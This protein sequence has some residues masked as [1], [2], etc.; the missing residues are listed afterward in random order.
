M[1]DFEGVL[2]YQV[3]TMKE[4]IAQDVEIRCKAALDE[5]RQRA[6]ALL[7][8]TRRRARQRVRQAVV[9]GRIEDPWT[10]Y[11]KLIEVEIELLRRHIGEARAAAAVEIGKAGKYKHYINM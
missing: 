3:R 9:E 8:E 11:Q 6:R 7:A 1:T 4:G 10:E 2:G 5:A